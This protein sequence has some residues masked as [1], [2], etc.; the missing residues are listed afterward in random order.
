[1]NYDVFISY[2][3]NDQKIVEAL[4][5]FLEE[6]GV[7]CFVAYRDIPK[8]R[9]WAREIPSAINESQMMVAVFSDDF[10]RS[11]ETD[12]EISLHAKTKKP[13]LTFRLCDTDYDGVK[14]YHL[15]SINWIDAFPDPAKKF[16]SLLSDI[17]K[18]VEIRESKSQ[19]IEVNEPQINR[20]DE[21][22][23]CHI[24]KKVSHQMIDQAIEIDRIVYNDDYQGI[25]EMCHQWWH[26]NAEI[27]VM[28]EDL[29]TKTIIGYINAMPLEKEYYDKVVSGEIIDVSTPSEYIQ[30]YDFPDIYNLYFSSIAIHPDYQN[31]SAFKLLYDAFLLHLLELAKREIYFSEIAADAVSEIGERMCKYVGMKKIRESSHDSNIYVATL[32]PPQLRATTL[33]SKK[34]IQR[35]SA[36]SEDLL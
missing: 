15:S 10:N 6:N 19:T 16:G 11:V 23:I 12:K 3:S 27:Y 9:D 34:V 33:L 17:K 14:A 24:G 25:A 22:F 18:L 4:S 8:G 21:N 20:V 35:Y 26:K 36:L 1:M 28:I 31:T 2:A 5:H 13:I 32:L 7:R 29:A 30:T